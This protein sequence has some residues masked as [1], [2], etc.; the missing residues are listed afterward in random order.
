MG[1][2]FAVRD[3]RVARQVAQEGGSLEGGGFRSAL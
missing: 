2:V 3:K 1:K